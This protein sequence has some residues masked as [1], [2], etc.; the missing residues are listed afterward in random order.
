MGW[1]AIPRCHHQLLY[2]VAFAV[3]NRYAGTDACASDLL[4]IEDRLQSNIFI[5]Q[6]FAG[7]KKIDK[8][9]YNRL[10]II[11]RE[12]HLDYNSAVKSV[13]ES[14]SPPHKQVI[15]PKHPECRIITIQKL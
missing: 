1:A 4:T 14:F 11:A 12:G 2:R 8:L 5:Q 6:Q 13:K 9:R 15:L 10:L 3:R 7:V